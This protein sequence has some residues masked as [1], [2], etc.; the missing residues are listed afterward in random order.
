MAAVTATSEG[1]APTRLIDRVTHPSWGGV[2]GVFVVTAGWVIGLRPLGDNSFLTHLATGRII[3]DTGSVPSHDVYTFTAAGEPWV[4]QSWLASLLY[5]TAESVGGLPAIRLTIGTL[6][7]ILA[8]LGW[9][10]LRPASGLVVRLALAAM[11]L[12]VGAQLW[13]ERPFMIGLVCLAL[14]ALAMDGRLD[15]RWLVPIGWVWVNTHGSFPLGLVLLVIG[16]VGRRLDGGEP[17]IE[18]RALRWAVLGTLVGAASPLGPRVLVFP[19]E[20]LSRQDALANVIEWN[21]PSFDST[22]QRVFILQ[23]VVAIVAVARKPSYRSA[24]ILGV[25]TAAALL[26]A[27]NLVVA[28]VLMLPIS[29]AGFAD[30][31]SLRTADRPRIARTVGV[32]ALALTLAVT[33]VR[34]DQ[35]DL[36]LDR[37]PIG[38]LAY[39]EEVGVD[40]QEVRLAEPDIVGNLVG[41]VYGPEQR[42]FY[43]DRFDMFPQ[44]VTDAH[45]ALVQTRVNM[46]EELDQYEIDLV[47]VGTTSPTAQVLLGDA[48]WRA[49][50]VDPD[51]VLICRRGSSVGGS[52][53]RC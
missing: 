26:G 14:T 30:I 8:G 24:L 11:F 17:A 45:V 47:V 48:A 42:A 52:A 36:N 15:P 34:L 50:Y 2:V 35:R 29:A 32:V 28:S 13:A 37:Y 21:A 1:H 33:M 9:T 23:L 22:S 43:D 25:F 53:G 40:T 10:L 6:G 31:G 18:L 27:R 4:V 12:T 20:L 38:A 41:Y 3:L 49:L 51:W 44:E 19:L 16:A 39:L 5:A 46:R 7:A